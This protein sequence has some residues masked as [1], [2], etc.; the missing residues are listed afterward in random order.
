MHDM[1]MIDV[2]DENTLGKPSERLAAY[3]F[4]LGDKDI[5][6]TGK[7]EKQTSAYSNFYM[8]NIRRHLY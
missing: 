4:L 2:N 8:Y 6:Y 5:L 1:L 3:S 7:V